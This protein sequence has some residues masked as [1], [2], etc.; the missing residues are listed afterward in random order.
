MKSIETSPPTARDKIRHEDEGALQH[1]DQ[2]HAV[3][4]IAPDVV[5]QL[6]HACLDVSVAMRVSMSGREPP[7]R[8]T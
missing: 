2:V 1:A 3:G 4:M 8:V 6:A 5:G 7:P